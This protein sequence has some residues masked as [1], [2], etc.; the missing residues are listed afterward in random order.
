[1][2]TRTK[3]V[4]LLIFTFLLGSLCGAMIQKILIRNQFKRFSHRVHDPEAFIQEFE[5]IIQPTET[6]KA[7]IRDVL[8]KHHEKMMAMKRKVPARMDSMRNELDAILT[9]EQKEKLRTS[10]LFK[11]KDDPPPPDD[12]HRGGR[13]KYR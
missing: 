11:H 8:E 1:M 4:F 10:W 3:T 13:K 5:E 6:Q 2:K 7:Q 12:E 9:E